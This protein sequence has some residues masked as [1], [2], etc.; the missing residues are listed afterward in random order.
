MPLPNNQIIKFIIQNKHPRYKRRD[1][2]HRPSRCLRHAS[3]LQPPLHDRLCRRLCP[4]PCRIKLPLHVSQR[5]QAHPAFGTAHDRHPALTHGF[6]VIAA[7]K[8]RRAGDKMHHRRGRDDCR[9]D[10][11]T[12]LAPT[13]PPASESYAI[14]YATVFERAPGDPCFYFLVSF[15]L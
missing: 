7:A 8:G 11:A 6:D 10:T 14:D 4:Q 1:V 3:W 5:P 9:C 12:L 2:L 15:G 13:G